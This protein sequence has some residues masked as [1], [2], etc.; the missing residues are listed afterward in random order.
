MAGWVGGWVVERIR[1]DGR[2]GEGWEIRVGGS[3]RN[4]C[5]GRRKSVE[6]G[7]RISRGG[8]TGWKNEW[9]G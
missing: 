1:K 4:G 3:I 5:M 9:I 6:E 8:G 7:R 2:V